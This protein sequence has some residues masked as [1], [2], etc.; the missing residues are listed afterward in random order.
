MERFRIP[1]ILAGIGLLAG[2]LVSHS[3]EAET[4]SLI[5]SLVALVLGGGDVI[6][7]A[8]RN[9]KSGQIFDENFLMSIAAIGAFCIGEGAEGA[10]VMLFYQVGEYFQDRAVDSARKSIGELMDIRPDY[11][12]LLVDGEPVRTDPFDVA[13]GAEILVRPGEKIPLD[14]VVISG[15]SAVDT[16]ALTG[17]SAPRNLAAGDEALSGCINL[18]GVLTI[19]V[20]KEFSESTASKILDL[21]ENA[22]IYKSKTEAFITRFARVYTPAVTGAALL[23]AVIPSLITGDWSLWVYRALSFLVVSCPCALVISVPMSFFGGIGAASRQ[24][25]LVKGGNYLEALAHT[26]TVVMDKTGT[27]T[28][29]KFAVQQV[30]PVEGFDAETVLSLAAAAEQHSSHPIALALRRAAD[31]ELTVAANVHEIAGQGVAA[32]ID[33]REILV[34]NGRLLLER[35]GV[36]VPEVPASATAVFVS[37]DGALAGTILIADELKEDA[38]SAIADL[39]KAGVA[40]IVMLTGDREAVATETAQ[41]L[42]ITEFS[43]GLLPADKV[44]ETEQLLAKKPVGSTL[45]FVGDGIN[46]APV[47]MRSDVGIAMGALGSDAAVEAADVVF[48]DDSPAK[49]AQAIGLAKATLANARQNIVFS[50]VVKLGFLLLVSLGYVGM[51]AAVFADVGVALLAILNAMRVLKK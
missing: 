10:A 41:I 33:G 38:K 49:I 8:V 26:S 1:R 11:A 16:A 9:L 37:V 12:N 50:L 23:L 51:W 44:T 36:V 35:H 5:L 3:F 34:D 47:L 32:V 45:V 48:M 27:L 19:R 6:L 13:V 43:A 29:G 2:A 21:V 20:T 18:N 4:L 46:D 22:A 17:E 42:G 28:K 31:G 30:L 15:E 14:G 24:G 25:I 39:R 40:H 7:G